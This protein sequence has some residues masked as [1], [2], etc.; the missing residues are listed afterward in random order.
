MAL[1]DGNTSCLKFE[2]GL[3]LKLFGRWS[4]NFYNDP[5]YLLGKIFEN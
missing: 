2:G 1:G 3:V 4:G 5:T